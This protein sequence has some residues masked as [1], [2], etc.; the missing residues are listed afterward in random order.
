MYR[1]HSISVVVPA[2]NEEQF[3][4]RVLA[5]IPTYVDRVYLVD[6]ASTDDTMATAVTYAE[7]ARHLSVLNA[8]RAVL[9]GHTSEKQQIVESST[10]LFPLQ[11]EF[12]R[13]VGG[14]IKTGYREAKREEDDVVIVINGDAQMDPEYIPKLADPIIDGSAGY[15]KGNRLSNYNCAERMPPWRLFGNVLLSLMTK[16]T[17]GY[18]QI[19]DS[20]NGYTAISRSALHELRLED[21]Y[22]DYGFLNDLLVELSIHGIEVKD[23]SMPPIYNDE[24]SWI[25]YR[26]FVPS[27]LVVLLTGLIR[28]LQAQ[29]LES[30]EK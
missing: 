12:N 22:E 17:T 29:Y 26:T 23:V 14:A 11:H 6:D 4:E 30:V 8:K 7:R 27:V 24:Q 25:K 10:T 28:R 20:Q 16:A 2:Y 3:I 5:D 13:G 18:W 19:M 15:T 21:L 1:N 9:P